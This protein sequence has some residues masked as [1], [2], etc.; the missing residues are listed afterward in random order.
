[1]PVFVD[2]NWGKKNQDLSSK[3]KVRGYPTVI[4]V[5]PDGN[6]L[7]RLGKRDAAAVLNQI[8]GVS[9]KYPGK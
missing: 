1:M 3:F 8:E 2:C 9:K 6:E 7:E 4:F 5:D